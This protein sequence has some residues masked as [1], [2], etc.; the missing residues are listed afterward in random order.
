MNKQIS[1]KIISIAH[2]LHLRLDRVTNFLAN[3]EELMKRVI[4]QR[5]IDKE[6]L[7]KRYETLLRAYSHEETLERG[8][9]IVMKDD[10]VLKDVSDLKI[11]DEIEIRLYK[12]TLK[13]EIKEIKDGKV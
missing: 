11:Q 5:K 6:L 12:G 9:S 2:A 4:D 1:L 7:L 3:K 13:A 8:F 10:K